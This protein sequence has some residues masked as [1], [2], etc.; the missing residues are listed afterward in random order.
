LIVIARKERNVGEAVYRVVPKGDRWRVEHEEQRVDYATKEAAFEAAVIA[1]Q[2][3]MRESMAVQIFVDSAPNVL[4][5]R[6]Q[7]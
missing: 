6:N 4:M 7:N 2:R 1:A 5:G 3:A